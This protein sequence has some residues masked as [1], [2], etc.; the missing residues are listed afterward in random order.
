M[1][2]GPLRTPILLVGVLDRQGGPL[3]A[4]ASAQAIDSSPRSLLAIKAANLVHMYASRLGKF[5][6]RKSW[7]SSLYLLAFFFFSYSS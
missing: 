2:Q 6:S 7:S 4:G 3:A 1:T 5:C